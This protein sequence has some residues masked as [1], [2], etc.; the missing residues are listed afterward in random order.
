MTLSRRGLL[1]WFV[2]VLAGYVAVGLVVLDIRARK[3][4]EE[5]TG[6]NSWGYRR[7]AVFHKES[8]ESRVAIVGGSAALGFGL[9]AQFSLAPVL[10]VRLN[11]PARVK[12]PNTFIR[13]VE[14]AE[15]GAGASSYVQTLRDYAYL[16][17]DV[18][19]IYD[20]YAAV[21]DTPVDGGRRGSW[22]FRRSGYMPV[23]FSAARIKAGILVD[24]PVAPTLRD[25]G[26]VDMSCRGMSSTYCAAMADAVKWGLDHGKAVMVVT[27]PFV[28][29]R[30]EAQQ[31]SLADSLHARFGADSH[32][33][34][35]DRGTTVDLQDQALSRDGQ[36]LTKAGIE[37][38][39]ESL[40]DPVLDA[41]GGLSTPVKQ[42]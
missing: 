32:F 15:P 39:A 22:I 38:I 19:C 34:Y 17:A 4:V 40:A 21:D 31:R 8:G 13:L 20:G 16:G 2:A 26:E 27:P 11:Q 9:P 23:L 33:T 28:S 29:R 30:H 1:V 3:D 5:H 37:R 24:A 18:I 6:L 41:I 36:H 10:E 42:P 7:Q 35:M 25:G 12:R 14:L